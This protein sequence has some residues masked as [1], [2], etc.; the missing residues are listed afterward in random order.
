MCSDFVQGYCVLPSL[1]HFPP[2]LKMFKEIKGWSVFY[3]KCKETSKDD[4]CYV[5]YNLSR[6]YSC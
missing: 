4:K 2:D 6:F 5:R 3:A 1:L